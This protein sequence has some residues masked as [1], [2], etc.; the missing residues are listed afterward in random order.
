MP[1]S[2]AFARLDKRALG[3]ALVQLL[4]VL[5]LTASQ[6]VNVPTAALFV[7]LAAVSSAYAPVGGLAA[8]VLTLPYFQRPLAVGGSEFA[9]SE[10][11]L[12]AA[13]L[14]C[15][16]N[17]VIL[18]A[19]RRSLF[20]EPLARLGHELRT[21]R[22]WLILVV[23]LVVGALLVIEPFDPDTRDAALREW[24]WTLL[25]PLVLLLLLVAYVSTRAER[26]LLAAALLTSGVVVAIHGFVDIAIGGG[27]AADSVR[28][29]S[30]PFPH[31]NAFALYSLRATVFGIALYAFAPRW[32]RWLLAPVALSAAALLASF[33]RGALLALF[34]ALLVVGWR[35]GLRRQIAILGAAAVAAAL[36]LLVAGGRM[37]SAFD[38]GSLSLR[39]ELWTAAARMIR[40]HP[41]LGLGPDQFYYAYNPRYIEPTGW[42]ERFTSHAHNLLLDAW[43]RLG[44]I[45]AVLASLAAWSIL[46]DALAVAVDRFRKDSLAAA[47]IVALFALLIHGLVDN[48][49]FS[50]D[51]ALSA[52]LLGWLAFGSR[53]ASPV[54]GSS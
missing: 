16:L 6:P 40:D 11:L 36:L 22:Y 47:A 25:E 46:R 28:R 27:V 9:V 34:L 44:I 31:P 5:L 26:G 33:S 21:R 2:E 3:V 20:V 50:Y 53:P 12:A 29:L 19:R 4:G 30:A 49:Y 1:A 17:F 8:V 24:R 32:R 43:V 37:L 7:L 48:A 52:W 38:G 23:A 15:G 45:G 41:V 13:V 10:L 39:A 54:E 14:G 35:F 51:L 18:T 42:P